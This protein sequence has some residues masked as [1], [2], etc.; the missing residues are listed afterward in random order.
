MGEWG[1][2]GF[3][4]GRAMTPARTYEIIAWVSEG[5]MPGC[6]EP[7]ANHEEALEAA[8]VFIRSGEAARAPGRMGRAAYAIV[9][10]EPTA[11]EAE[12]WPG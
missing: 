10:G 3:V 9:E 1:Q 5:E 6:F 4:S 8:K 12:S 11:D 7:P 2:A